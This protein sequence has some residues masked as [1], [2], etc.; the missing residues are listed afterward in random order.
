MIR[1]NELNWKYMDKIIQNWNDKG[2]RNAG[3]IMEK[4]SGQ[5][6]SNTG[7]ATKPVAQKHGAPNR[8]EVERLTRLHNKIKDE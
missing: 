4:D 1:T 2:L 8:E 3:D 5:K 7:T 6:Q